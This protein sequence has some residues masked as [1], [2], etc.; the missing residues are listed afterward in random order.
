MSTV[1]NSLSTRPLPLQPQEPPPSFICPIT[2][3]I[4]VDPM[5]DKH[6]HTFEKAAITQWLKTKTTC[7]LSNQQM[8]LDELAPNRA[9][10]EVIESYQATSPQG[11]L[12][13]D[14]KT[15]PRP[16]A[17]VQNDTLSAPMLVNAKDLENKNKL[18]DAEQL[19]LLAL[20]FTSKSEDYAHLPRLFEKKGEKERAAKAYIVLA[21]LQVAEG[22]KKDAITSLKASLKF[23]AE[24]NIKEKLA[25]LLGETGQKQE[26]AL[27]FLELSQQ[28]LYGK[29]SLKATTFCNEALQAF[30][31]H[32]ETWKTLAALQSDAS[33]T[34]KILLKG[35]NEPTMSIKDRIGLCRT[36]TLK[37]PDSPQAEVLFLKLSQLEMEDKIKAMQTQLKEQGLKYE[38]VLKTLKEDYGKKVQSLELSMKE[39]MNEKQFRLQETQNIQQRKFQKIVFGKAAWAKYFGDVGVEPPLPPN[40]EQILNGPCPIW[41]GEIVRDTHL[42]VLI[43]QTVNGQPLMF[44]TLYKI[45]Q[46]PL[47]GYGTQL[48]SALERYK[49]SPAPASRWM[50]ITRDVFPNT[51]NRPY[52]E[53]QEVVHGYGYQVPAVLD[54]TTAI[55]VEYVRS[56]NRLYGGDVGT[57]THCQEKNNEDKPLMVGNFR[58]PQGLTITYDESGARPSRYGTAGSRNL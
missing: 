34:L 19:Y 10:K 17:Q 43:P 2:N 22:K 3:D 54:V 31:G 51:R 32:A 20:Q 14:D 44:K 39:L 35:A 45:V 25:R 55:V 27:L 36:A 7:P 50:L 16:S 57:Y 26:A 21:D 40:I 9:L 46:S 52:V 15:V 4:M 24:P 47:Q 11:S 5:I 48:V 13:T 6:G 56:G 33:G 12:T 58:G 8:S 1:Q 49:D 42:L 30:P 28:A 41:T 29:D 53:Q 37:D 38:E 23:L 18:Q